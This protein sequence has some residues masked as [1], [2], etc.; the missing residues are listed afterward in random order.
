MIDWILPAIVAAV[1][2]FFTGKVYLKGRKDA[3]DKSDKELQDALDD[4]KEVAKRA[5]KAGDRAAS[6]KLRADDGHKRK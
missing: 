6:R 2:A 5:R 4:V 3:R 1:I